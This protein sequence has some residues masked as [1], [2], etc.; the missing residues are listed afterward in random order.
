MKKIVLSIIMVASAAFTIQAQ[1]TEA[2]GDLRQ[3]SADTASG[4][5]KGGV[6]SINGSNTQLQNW[7]AGGENTLAGN[8]LF[9]YFMNYQKGPHAW[10]NSLDF[11]YGKTRQGEKTNPFVKTDDKIDILSK[12]GRRAFSDFYYAALLN[13]KTQ[14]DEGRK[15]T[16][17]STY[18]VISRF[19]A[20]AYIIG[21]I[22]LDYKPN[23]YFSAFFAPITARYT[24]VLDQDLADQGAFG[25]EAA[26][27]NDANQ[28]IKNGAN[29]R[30]EF[31]GY[32][33]LIYTKSDFKAELLQNLSF[34]SKLDLFSNYLDEP[35]N[36]D[37]SWENQL[38]FNINKYIT[39]S[40]NTHL[41]NDTDIKNVGIDTN[42]D[43]VDDKM[44][45]KAQYKQI[46]AVGFTYKF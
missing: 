6:I 30:Q 16:S 14:I 10:D 5:K 41:I 12:Y 2:E 7:A 8:I 45:S 26:E 40:F 29:Y 28:K 34:T 9:S 17:D 42:N 39:V 3:V 46:L 27:Y 11:G 33:R 23:Q 13:F 1:V 35:Q 22:G 24:I 15:Y 18:D 37:V 19:M 25:V 31:G 20:P 32:V 36:I 4:W 44:V 38:A 21:A 43:G